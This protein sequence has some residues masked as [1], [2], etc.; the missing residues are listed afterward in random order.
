MGVP[1]MSRVDWHS[2][3]EQVL[4]VIADRALTSARIAYLTSLPI[5]AVRRV[6]RDLGDKRKVHRFALHY[7]SLSYTFVYRRR[8]MCKMCGR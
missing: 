2:R 3:A 8:P 4:S 1:P 5:G 7:D 6:L